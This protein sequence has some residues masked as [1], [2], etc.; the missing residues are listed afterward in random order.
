MSTQLIFYCWDQSATD[1]GG[2]VSFE[3]Q[4]IS[5]CS[6]STCAYSGYDR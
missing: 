5:A 4:T 1:M 6:G 2:V 3:R